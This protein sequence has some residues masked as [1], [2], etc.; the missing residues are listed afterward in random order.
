MYI[1]IYL[2]IHIEGLKIPYKPMDPANHDCKNA[3]CL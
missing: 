2:Y 3:A 1:Y